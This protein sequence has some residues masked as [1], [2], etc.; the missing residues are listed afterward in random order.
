[1]AQTAAGWALVSAALLGI[2][3]AV[4]LR[5]SGTREFGKWSGGG[6][7]TFVGILACFSF[8]AFGGAMILQRS[9]VWA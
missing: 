9:A 4:Y 2:L 5:I 8:M 1:M 6:K 3:I 7:T